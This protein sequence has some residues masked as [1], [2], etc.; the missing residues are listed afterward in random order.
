MW[1]PESAI[2]PVFQQ[3]PSNFNEQIV[4]KHRAERWQPTSGGPLQ[5]QNMVRLYEG[6]VTP[7]SGETWESSEDSGPQLKQVLVLQRSQEELLTF[8]PPTQMNLDLIQVFFSTFGEQRAVTG[9][10]TVE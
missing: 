9:N 3:R 5:N 2:L 7:S 4:S 10:N 8:L 1:N 6:L